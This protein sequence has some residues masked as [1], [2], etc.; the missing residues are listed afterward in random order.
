MQLAVEIQITDDNQNSPIVQ[1]AFFIARPQNKNA[2]RH[3]NENGLAWV[4][5]Q[6]RQILAN[7]EALRLQQE[8]FEHAYRRLENISN[9]MKKASLAEQ[10][11]MPVLADPKDY[12]AS[13]NSINKIT[14]AIDKLLKEVAAV[15]RAHRENSVVLDN[16][17][18]DLDV[19]S[20]LLSSATEKNMKEFQAR[21][22]QNA[23]YPAKRSITDTMLTISQYVMLAAAVVTLGSFIALSAGFASPVLAT[24][25]IF[26]A[27]VTIKTC[28]LRIGLLLSKAFSELSKEHPIASEQ[29]TI[30]NEI[31]QKNYL[32]PPPSFGR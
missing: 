29:K 20:N 1:T 28:F 27:N 5:K 25:C 32:T 21:T 12:K 4:T 31:N 3:E 16:L 9:N 23:N 15:G 24:T 11:A 13:V 17:R 7:Q 22:S 10:A 19:T 26:A 8:A 2:L 6:N 14:S 30:A 18:Y